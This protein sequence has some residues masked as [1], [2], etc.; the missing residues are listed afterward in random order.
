M[1]LHDKLNHL[2]SK[3]SDMKINLQR[4]KEEKIKKKQKE[5]EERKRKQA[6]KGE[7]RRKDSV[8]QEEKVGLKGFVTQ[9]PERQQLHTFQKDPYSPRHNIFYVSEIVRAYKDEQSIA[10]EHIQTSLQIM[11]YFEKCEKPSDEQIS[12]K[13]LKLP[14]RKGYEGTFVVMQTRRPLFSI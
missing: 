1:K 12:H 8:V 9:V 13:K 11:A 14:R 10:R 4:K 7:N 5:E 3:I 2:E 6:E